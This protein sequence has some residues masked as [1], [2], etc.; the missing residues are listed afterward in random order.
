MDGAFNDVSLRL[1][2]GA[3]KAEVIARLDRSAR[4]LRRARRL[5]PRRPALAPLPRRRDR[6]EPRLRHGPAGDLPRR[7]RLPAQH[8][9]R[10]AWSARS[11]TRSRCSRPSATRPQR[12]AALPRLR[13]GRRGARR[14][15]WRAARPLARRL[16]NGVYVDFYRFPVLRFE[17]GLA[18]VGDRRRGV[19]GG[20]AGRRA[21]R[22]APRAVAAAGRGDAARAA[23][24]LP[25]GPA[26]AHRLSRWLPAPPRM[27]WRNVAR[28]PLRAALS[29]LGI[30]LA[31]AILVVGRYFVD[32]IQL[33]RRRA[34][35]RGA[36]R[37]RDGRLPRAAAASASHASRRCRACCARSPSAS[38]RRACASSTRTGASRSS[39]SSR[40]A[41]CGA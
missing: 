14:G 15:R 2:P 27:I 8:R 7:R 18:V 6:A 39:G 17:P 35:P 24:A 21:G 29:V 11:A 10:R 30:A 9:A 3:V 19:G 26:R 22:R 16:V 38:C 25:G 20:R 4:A 12:G 5:R 41:S 31:V 28:R 1:A 37:G 32:A 36:A 40:P 13:G 23:G 34:V 33:P